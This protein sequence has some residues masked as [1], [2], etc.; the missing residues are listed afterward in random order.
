VPLGETRTPW[1][2]LPAPAALRCEEAASREEAAPETQ[3]G[4]SIISTPGEK[5]ERP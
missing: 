1:L 3:P 2:S 5:A 4:S